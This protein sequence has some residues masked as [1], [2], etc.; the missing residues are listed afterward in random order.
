MLVTYSPAYSET[1]ESSTAEQYE[2]EA[3]KRLEVIDSQGGIDRNE[4]KEIC[5]LYGYRFFHN[6]GWDPIKDGGDVW[7]GTVLTHWDDQPLPEKVEIEKK[8]GAVSWALGPKVTEIDHKP[9]RSPLSGWSQNPG[10]SISS[11]LTAVSNAARL[12]LLLAW[13]LY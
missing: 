12:C 1:P 5:E 10:I 11:I 7:V 9:F 3:R 4:A 13:H 8:T 6:N 2:A